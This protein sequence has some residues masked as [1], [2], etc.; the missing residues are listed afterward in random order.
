MLFLNWFSLYQN[1]IFHDFSVWYSVLYSRNI[2]HTHIVLIVFLFL[3]FSN[4]IT[5]LSMKFSVKQRRIE[6]TFQQIP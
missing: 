4:K 5:A 2:V 1:V 6:I 3:S